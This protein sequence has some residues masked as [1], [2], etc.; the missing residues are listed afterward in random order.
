MPLNRGAIVKLKDGLTV[1]VNWHRDGMVGFSYLDGGA[2]VVD[3]RDVDPQYIEEAGSTAEDLSTLSIDDIRTRL[4]ELRSA[5][6]RPSEPPKKSRRK[7]ITTE[8]PTDPEESARQKFAAMT[9][10][11]KEQMLKILL[12]ERMQ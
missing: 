9:P 11:Q 6:R 7:A 12:G 1:K 10:E 3:E 2:G 4:D 5:R 8:E